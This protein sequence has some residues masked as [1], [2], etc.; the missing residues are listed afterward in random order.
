ME[1]KVC[2]PLV[3]SDCTWENGADQIGCNMCGAPFCRTQKA[4]PSRPPLWQIN[5]NEAVKEAPAVA[6][7]VA[8]SADAIIPSKQK[9]PEVFSLLDSD[10]KGDAMDTFPNIRSKNKLPPHI[11]DEMESLLTIALAKYLVRDIGPIDKIVQEVERLLTSANLSEYEKIVHYKESRQR[12]CI[13]K[14]RYSAID[15]DANNGPLHYRDKGACI[16]GHFSTKDHEHLMTPDQREIMDN[17]HCT[18]TCFAVFTRDSIEHLLQNHGVTAFD[19][20]L[21]P[22]QNGFVVIDFKDYSHSNFIA[23]TGNN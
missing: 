5:L 21:D 10:D 15:Q 4:K 6:A 11:V 3:C 18:A 9:Q 1:S 12:S 14:Q 7:A 22:I 13:L 16:G 2:L 8:A 23:M 17:C 20:E 19:A